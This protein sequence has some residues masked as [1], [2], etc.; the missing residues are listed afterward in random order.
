M[1]IPSQNM[2]IEQIY[3]QLLGGGQRAIAI[4]SAN[5]GE[6]VTSIVLSLAQRNLLAG[7][8]TLVVDLNLYRTSFNR[9]LNLGLASSETEL[10]KPEL[11]EPEL[12]GQPQLVMADRHGIAL[13]G[14]TAPSGRDVIIKLRKPGT[15]EQCIATWHREYDSVIIDTTPINQINANNIPAERVA[16]A[17]D[18]ALL[19][20]LAGKT[21]E[22]M[23]SDAVDKLTA[24]NASLLGCIFNDRDNPTLKNELLRETERLQPRFGKVSHLVRR[25]IKK[26]HLLSLEV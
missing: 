17:C 23:V 11:L 9:A 22:A 8:T 6:G 13:T 10:L 16:A 12:L 2:E 26:S 7:N 15:L 14:I 3:S 5:P 24:A 25:W 18:G 21:T 1:H 4:T 19:V 20:V